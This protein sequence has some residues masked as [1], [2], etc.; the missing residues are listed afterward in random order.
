MP[1]RYLKINDPR[2]DNVEWLVRYVA[3][4]DTYTDMRSGKPEDKVAKFG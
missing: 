3:N 2:V 4:G 1:N